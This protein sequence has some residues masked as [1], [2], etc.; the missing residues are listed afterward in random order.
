MCERCREWQASADRNAERD[1]K[2]FVEAEEP[3][4]H[5]KSRKGTSKW[6]GRKVGREHKWGVGRSELET[7]FPLWY[8]RLRAECAVCH[9]KGNLLPILECRKCGEHSPKPA[10][11]SERTTRGTWIWK[12]NT[13]EYCPKCG[14][15][16]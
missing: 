15:R 12:S 14:Y 9:K 13:P 2:R 11:S 1:L 8:Y 10:P 16:P 5:R 4:P 6:C 7:R 3:L